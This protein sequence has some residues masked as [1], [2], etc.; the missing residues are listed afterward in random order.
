MNFFEE[1]ERFSFLFFSFLFFSFSFP[2]TTQ[3]RSGTY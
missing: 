1:E 2:N 3:P